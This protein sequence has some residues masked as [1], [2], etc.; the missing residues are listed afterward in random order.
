[1]TLAY[2]YIRFS[3]PDQASGNSLDRQQLAIDEFVRTHNLTL[4]PSSAFKD[5]GI[6]GFRGANLRHGLGEFIAEVDAGKVPRGSYLLMESL[7][8]M[9]R[10]RV[11]E[12]LTLLLSLI[13][14]GIKVV[15]LGDAGARV[16]DKQT[17]LPTLFMTLSTMHRANDESEMKSM[18]VRAAW[19]AKRRHAAIK[20]V[21][22]RAPEWLY[23]DDRESVFK[24][25][26]ERVN[27]ILKMFELADAGLG[28]GR[29][30]KFLNTNGFP[31]FRS[32]T[33]GWQASS[34]SKLLKNRSLLGYYQ[35]HCISYDENTG[36]KKRTPD[37]EEIAN[38]YPKVIDEGLFLR[39]SAKKYSPVAPLVGRQG[40][41]L[42]NLFTGF[43]YCHRCGAPMSLAN[44]GQGTKGGRYLVC[45]KARRGMNCKYRAWNYD[46]VEMYVLYAL[47]QLDLAAV[48]AG[49]DTDE[50]RQRIRTDVA[51]AAV[52]LA[53]IE[54]R[55][56]ELSVALVEGQGASIRTLVNVVTKL[57]LS[58][59]EKKNELEALKAQELGLGAPIK[60][61]ATYAQGLLQLYDQMYS[62]NDE[63]RYVLRV[64]LRQQI[65]RLLEKIE[66]MAVGK[67]EP[68]VTSKG[69]NSAKLFLLFKDGCRKLVLP[70]GKNAIHMEDL[71]AHSQP[72]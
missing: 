45:S 19:Q 61:P 71:P 1:M 6:S 7:D 22:R 55:L 11:M 20:P 39:V 43:I 40:K 29:I 72:D 36:V 38:Y 24:P 9:S 67:D 5:L 37:G 8:R 15:T 62:V 47:R 10:Q 44:K 57:E 30:V 50:R 4:A 28:R 66:V 27:T 13:D 17:D 69:N 65:S 21:S 53:K 51:R 23:F 32:P 48:I 60:D 26:P 70:I 68:I 14:K 25:V 35:P 42:S 58:H 12:S 46:D 16:L 41:S 2:T 54:A 3:T 18:R 63:D 64:R 56:S 31:S 49:V 59:E 33:Q 34:V 52:E